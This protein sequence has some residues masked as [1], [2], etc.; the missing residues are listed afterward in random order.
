MLN[1]P[2]KVK[3]GWRNYIV[4]QGEHRGCDDGDIYGQIEYEKRK[5]YLYKELDQ[6]EKS[7]CLLHEITHGILFNMGNELRTN[8][9]FVT[10]FSENLYQFIKDNPNMFRQGESK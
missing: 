10:A 7:V 6:D 4:T 8:E 3:I 5:I 1:I 9:N 2:D